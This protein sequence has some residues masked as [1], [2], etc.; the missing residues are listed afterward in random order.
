MVWNGSGVLPWGLGLWIYVSCVKD[1]VVVGQGT[2][3]V[4]DP[5]TVFVTKGFYKI[6]RNPM[7]LGMMLIL[8]GEAILFA[9]AWLLV[10][11]LIL[12]LSFH[13]FVVGVEEPTLRRKFG[14]SYETY[15]KSVPR[16]LPVSRS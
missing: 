13:W 12:W 4:W 5:P 6:M 15:L 14:N 3:A 10:Y 16:W 9:S 8:L 2:P 7:Y 11:A 1:F